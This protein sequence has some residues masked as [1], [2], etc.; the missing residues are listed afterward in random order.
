MLFDFAFKHPLHP[1][2]KGLVLMQH[3]GYIERIL[4]NSYT[5]ET[6]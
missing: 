1:T 3:H 4:K 5:K 2:V 6:R